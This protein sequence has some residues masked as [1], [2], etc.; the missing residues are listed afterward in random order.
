MS[1]CVNLGEAC[2][3]EITARRHALVPYQVVE[4]LRARQGVA[5]FGRLFRLQ[6]LQGGGQRLVAR[7]VEDL[8]HDGLR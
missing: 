5:A 8:R 2:N 7:T 1:G 3:P 4:V 6:A